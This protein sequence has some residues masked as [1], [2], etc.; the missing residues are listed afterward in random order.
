VNVVARLLALL[1]PDRRRAGLAVLLQVLTVVA[2]VALLGTSAWLLSTAALRPSIA[3][4]S[5]AIVGVRAFGTA[6][7]VLRYLERLATHDV[8]LRL[9]SRLRG[10]VFRALVPLAPARL[11]SRRS[12]DLLARVVEDV[13]ALETFYAR[14][15]GPSL[16][17]VV[18]IGL[19]GVALLPF[20]GA[21]SLAAVGGLALSGVVFPWL[22]FRLSAGP[23]A[24]L[25]TQRADLA[26]RLVDAIQGQA[27]LL[28]SGGEVL[29]AAGLADRS[30]LALAEQRRLVSASAVGGAL[31]GLGADL[32]VL[33]V[34]GLA[35]PS[36]R[37][38]ALDGVLLAVAALLALAAF[39]AVAAL[40]AA[41][42]AMAS[43]RASAERLFE[44]TGQDPAVRED[45][46]SLSSPPRTLEI[47]DLRFA[48][49]GAPRPALDGVSLRLEPD[50]RVALV[51]P[52]GSGKSTVVS[53]LLRFWDVPSGALWLDGRD[54]RSLR[55]V[56]VRAAITVSTQGAHL[57]TGTLRENLTLGV[58]DAT[59]AEMNAAL[60]RARLAGLVARLPGGLDTAIGEG[61]HR[62]SGGER[63]RL[64][65][66][67]A[68][69]RK[70][71]PFLVLDEPTAHIDAATEGEVLRE[72]IHA[73]EGR[74][75][76]LVTHR[77]VGLEAFDEVLVLERGR[78]VER[79]R[80]PALAASGGAF[81]RLL[82]LQR[83]AAVLDDP[84]W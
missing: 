30:R 84:I 55:P 53:L 19:A 45:G 56:D 28:A 11:V 41:W 40:P 24:R 73:G 57:L 51:G 35:I 65:L 50:R 12:G 39:E 59:D 31:A 8:T 23:A 61:G 14:V 67:R 52:S 42:Q 63:Q 33:A 80:S 26:A 34:I 68:F 10:A 48:Y 22:A 64:S 66:A 27:D 20:G 69:L 72:I 25:A 83:A 58:P 38:G 46:A 47:R 49:P 77:L 36:V 62:L 78:V 21:V 54:A 76:L 15:L 7:P 74:G 17:A 6:R 3:A 82:A 1:R 16:A 29:F 70:D 71:A 9:A 81:A 32:T 75:T 43:A 2:G 79:G 37:S 44:V 18:L 4:L 60:A 13:S 5:V